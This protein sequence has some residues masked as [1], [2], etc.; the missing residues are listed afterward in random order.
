[1]LASLN[2]HDKEFEGKL[3]GW[4]DGASWLCDSNHFK[5]WPHAS[6]SF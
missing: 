5:V 2:D 4:D 1:M 3:P 6:I